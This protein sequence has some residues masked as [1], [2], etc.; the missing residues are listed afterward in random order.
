[1]NDPLRT[2][3]GFQWDEGNAEK[4]WLS[5][6]VKRAECEQV[7]FQRPLLVAD[8]EVHS[9]EELRWYALGR[10]LEGRRLFVAFTVRDDLVRVISARDMSR[11]ERR[12]YESAEE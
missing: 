11:G 4:N 6:R 9:Q 7:F 10:T 3:S 12:I 5:H 2:A 8:D 1:M